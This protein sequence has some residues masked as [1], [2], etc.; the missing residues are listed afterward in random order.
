VGSQTRFIS[1]QPKADGS[2]PIINASIFVR[3]TVDVVISNL[4]IVPSIA[5]CRS[6]NPELVNA[7]SQTQA[8]AGVRANAGVSTDW[9]DA[10]LAVGSLGGAAMTTV[11]A[12][13]SPTGYR[14]IPSAELYAGV[15]ID[16]GAASLEM[17]DSNVDMSKAAGLNRTV[18]GVAG[19]LNAQAQFN[20]NNPFFLPDVITG[21]FENVPAQ[22]L[23]LFGVL[24]N[25][26]SDTFGYFDGTNVENP[27]RYGLYAQN[28]DRVQISG[29]RF[30]GANFSLVLG[31]KTSYASVN[32]NALYDAA[33]AEDPELVNPFVFV[34]PKT[35]IRLGTAGSTPTA[36][37]LPRDGFEAQNPIDLDSWFTDASWLDLNNITTSLQ[38]LRSD[39]FGNINAIGTHVNLGLITNATDWENYYGVAPRTGTGL[40]AIRS[41][42]TLNQSARPGGANLTNQT[43]ATTSGGLTQENIGFYPGIFNA[44]EE[45]VRLMGTIAVLENTPW[46][47]APFIGVSV[48]AYLLG[49]RDT[50]LE[51]RINSVTPTLGLL[52]AEIERRL[53]PNVTAWLADE[54]VD[55]EADAKAKIAPAIFDVPEV[56]NA[57][58]NWNRNYQYQY[59][60]TD[61]NVVVDYTYSF[62]VPITF[63]H[64]AFDV[65]FWMTGGP[66]ET[67]TVTTDLAPRV[68][69]DVNFTRSNTRNVTGQA[70]P[71]GKTL[72]DT[73]AF[74][75][76]LDR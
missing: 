28:S 30:V 59:W 57:R 62:G 15:V 39:A 63:T 48:G 2:N 53:A 14:C 61:T 56:E 19:G 21:N 47:E 71:V 24:V 18:A 74:I 70:M 32:L 51:S 66:N 75:D 9:T 8:D 27:G 60:Y 58:V 6:F 72:A 31:D 10:G 76:W 13:I 49:R 23:P 46:V 22:N 3:D 68:F 7:L 1:G 45:Y 41:L 52:P 34:N 40:G 11:N 5:L 36:I 44:V 64:P 42:G 25:N 50:A 16:S 17:Y 20:I 43:I 54:I 55:T 33:Y 69:R 67:V 35:S 37:V 12:A 73:E 29:G 26:V 65:N 4:D 38:A